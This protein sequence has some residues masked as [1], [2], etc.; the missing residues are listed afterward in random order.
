MIMG[1]LSLPLVCCGVAWAREMDG[2][3]NQSTHII[4]ENCIAVGSVVTVYHP[5]VEK[6]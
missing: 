6:I 1:E 5:L 3:R 4:R 2:P